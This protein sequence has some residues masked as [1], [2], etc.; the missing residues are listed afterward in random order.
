MRAV[1]FVIALF[2][3]VLADASGSWT[4]VMHEGRRFVPVE[5]VATFYKMT[6]RVTGLKTIRLE[7]RG[8]SIE[9]RGGGRDIRINGVKY[10]LCFPTVVK[11]GRVLISAMDVTKIIEPVMRPQKIKEATEVRTVILDPG[12]GGHDSG[13]RGRL[14]VE[15]E[16]ALDV[17]VRAKRLLEARGFRVLLTRSSDV[18]IP[19]EKRSAFANRHTNA[20][21]VSIHF[22]KGRGSGG[23]GIE[24]FCL[25]PR[26]VPSMDEEHLSYSDYKYHPGHARDPE[27]IALAT[28]VHASLV[29]RINLPDRGIK[30]ARF[31]VIRATQ[32]P[33]ILVEGGFMN[34]PVDSRL[35]ASATYRQRMAE[36]IASGIQMFRGAVSG[37]PQTAP[38]SAVASAADPT[39]IPS[40]VAG[41]RGADADAESAIAAA[42][43]ALA[44]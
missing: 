39:T 34:N 22:N 26:G 12:H 31:H 17:A 37:V 1:C 4:V 19:L 2:F 16:A 27:N 9:L 23:T 11:N 13:A 32:I 41:V 18:F 42:A 25:A 36:A 5:N 24:T 10:V 3:A 44:S 30:R 33:S 40:L 7:A 15:K 43:R 8:R 28:A 29:R 21:F 14:G 35:I 6:R 20:V 38:P